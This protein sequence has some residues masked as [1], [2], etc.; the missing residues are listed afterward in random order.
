MEKIIIGANA[1]NL[2]SNTLDFACYLAHLTHSTLSGIFLANP[3][4]E[5]VPVMKIA[6]GM[7][8]VE[9]IV[10]QDIPGTQERTRLLKENTRLFEE[11]CKNRGVNCSTRRARGV[12]VEVMIAESRFADLIVA[13]PETSFG[14]NKEEVPTGFIK[15]LL[16]KS[17]CPVAIAPYSF[18][19]INEIVLA[20]DGSASSVFAIKQFTHL[21]PAYSNKKL[22]I[23]QVAGHEHTDDDE[24]T[25]LLSFLGEHYSDISFKQLV[26]KATDELFGF[27][28]GR[29][30]V[31]I[32][33]GAFGR[34]TISDFFK[35]STAELVLKTVNLPVFIAHH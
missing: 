20:Y 2:N 31:F 24:K 5:E 6:F 27:F 10:A 14:R 1:A 11:I 26:G 23:L 21:F 28:L 22:T 3:E 16:A 13:D 30:D 4:G 15:E 9:T 32:V 18:Y 8:Y 33:M 19:G 29:K 25:K 7:P 34:S 35:K 17:E 12:P